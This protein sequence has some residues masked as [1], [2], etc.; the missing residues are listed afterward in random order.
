MKLKSSYLVTL[1]FLFLVVVFL[2]QNRTA[3]PIK[4]LIGNPFQLELS[5]IIIISI[6]VGVISTIGI[7]YLMNRKK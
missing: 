6:V 4:I 7:V 3:V 5:L 1:M 2:D